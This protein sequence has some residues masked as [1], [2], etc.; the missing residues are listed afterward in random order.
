MQ[1][2]SVQG[3]I[4]WGASHACHLLAHVGQRRTRTVLEVMGGQKLLGGLSD[5]PRSYTLVQGCF[6]A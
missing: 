4:G 5:I 2:A 3:R 1:E 6:G